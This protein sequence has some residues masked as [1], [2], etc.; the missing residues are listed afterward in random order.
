MIIKHFATANRH[1][2]P[3]ICVRAPMAFAARGEKRI[4]H[5]QI[6]ALWPLMICDVD[7]KAN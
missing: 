7:A 3:G 5:M 1:V 2:H 4:T 6:I